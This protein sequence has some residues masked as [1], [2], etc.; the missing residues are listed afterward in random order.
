MTKPRLAFFS[1]LSA[2]AGYVVVDGA[3]G[4]WH[5]LATAL[6]VSLAAGGALSFN[7]WSE[8]RLDRQMDRTKNRPLPR[9]ALSESAGLGWSLLLTGLG[10]VTLWAFANLASAVIALSIFVIYGVIY[11][12]LKRRTRWATEVGSVAGAL[13][14]LL[15]S[16]AAGWW[17]HPS[18]LLL[19]GVLLFWQMPHFYGIGWM[20]R[21][22]YRRAGFRLLPVLDLDGRRTAFWSLAYTIGLALFCLV[23]WAIGWVGPVFGIVALA[24]SF[25]LLHR[26]LRF[27]LQPA[28]SRARTLFLATVLYLPPIM[29]AVCVDSWI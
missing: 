10:F 7:Q 23:F 4:W 25:Y 19:T 18:A 9:G 20:H 21:E 15:G 22:D 3:H 24:G 11:T 27:F 28:Y 14:P 12:P 26:S 29:A 8:W 16:A 17:S 5:F 2:M 6:G 1:I 13:P